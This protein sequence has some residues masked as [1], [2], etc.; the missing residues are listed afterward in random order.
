MG[1]RP[2]GPRRQAARR[3]RAGDDRADCGPQP[4]RHDAELG[5][6]TLRGDLQSNR[7]VHG[8]KSGRAAWNVSSLT[9]QARTLRLA[10]EDLVAASVRDATCHFQHEQ[11]TT[12]PEARKAQRRNV[13]R[14]IIG[15]ES[16]S[17]EQVKLYTQR[18]GA[19]R[20]DFFRQKQEVESG[21]FDGYDQA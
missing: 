4:G 10:T 9:S 20:A 18:A 16:D 15:K 19:S 8:G 12:S 21:E 5:P 14:E 2:P 17:K 11:N 7:D 13:I 6:P 1:Y 3:G